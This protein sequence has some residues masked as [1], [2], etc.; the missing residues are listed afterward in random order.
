M[1]QWRYVAPALPALLNGAL[2]TL[3]A[4][5]LAVILGAVV[6]IALTLIRELRIK[7]LD[8]LVSAHVSLMRYTAIHSNSLHLLRTA[9]DEAR[10]ATISDG[11][12]CP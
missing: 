4:S 2:V 10:H 1:F 6:G 3:E 7:V 8:Y 11:S 12:H 9:S 5:L